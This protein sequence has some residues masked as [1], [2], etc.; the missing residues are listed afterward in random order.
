[1]LSCWYWISQ[2]SLYHMYFLIFLKVPLHMSGC[3]IQPLSVSLFLQVYNTHVIKSYSVLLHNSYTIC[4]CYHITY[5]YLYVHVHMYW[6]SIFSYVCFM[7]IC[8]SDQTF[9]VSL[10]SCASAQVPQSSFF[11]RFFSNHL[12][13]DI[14]EGWCCDSRSLS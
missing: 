2:S 11:F 5:F 7:Y 10:F 6:W 13:T 1:M 4:I 14:D 8:F 9:I 12:I 3:K